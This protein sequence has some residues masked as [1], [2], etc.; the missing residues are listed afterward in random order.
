M[1]A[2]RHCCGP[3]GGDVN[4]GEPCLLGL[5]EPRQVTDAWPATFY[6]P[7]F[8]PNDQTST[9]ALVVP[10]LLRREAKGRLA[11]RQCPGRLTNSG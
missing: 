5:V 7:H 2:A 1:I 6:A 10:R 8:V 3:V 4:L 11:G 9:G